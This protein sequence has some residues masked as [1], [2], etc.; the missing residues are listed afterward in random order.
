M[1][2]IVTLVL[3]AGA[4]L[5]GAVGVLFK[6]V[7]RQSKEQIEITGRVGNLEGRHDAIEK[8]S[9]DTL[10]TVHNAI[11]NRDKKD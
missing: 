6:I 1:G 9:S 7:M 2:D 11:T 3:A 10:E 5:A 4:G 8:L